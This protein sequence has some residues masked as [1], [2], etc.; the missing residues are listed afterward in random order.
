MLKFKSSIKQSSRWAT[1]LLN[2]PYR[3]LNSY[4]YLKYRKCSPLD[5]KLPWFTYDAIDYIERKINLNNMKLF[6]YGSGASTLYFAHK[7]KM[8]V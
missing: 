2:K 8:L 3:L 1:Y 5:V 7:V 4:Q 6:E